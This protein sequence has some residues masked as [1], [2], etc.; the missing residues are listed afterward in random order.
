M[1]NFPI[2]SYKLLATS[3]TD[4]MEH[5]SKAKLSNSILLLYDNAYNLQANADGLPNIYKNNTQMPHPNNQVPSGQNHIHPSSIHMR[6]PLRSRYRSGILHISLTRDDR[7]KPTWISTTPTTNPW[8]HSP[9]KQLTKNSATLMRESLPP[10]RQRGN[11][12]GIYQG[13]KQTITWGQ[14]YIA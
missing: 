8:S 1:A 14:Q 13:K 12:T 10:V 7:D 3:E 4:T 6:I 5:I 2:H 9:I 11:T